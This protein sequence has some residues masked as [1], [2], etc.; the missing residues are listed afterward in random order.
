[1]QTHVAVG[2]LDLP[3]RSPKEIGAYRNPVQR[4][5]HLSSAAPFPGWMMQ[6]LRAVL[7]WSGAKAQWLFNLIYGGVPAEF[8]SAFNLDESVKR[9][10]AVTRELPILTR[11]RVAQGEVSKSYVS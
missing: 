1:M 3:Q 4:M 7:R 2:R 8:D 10:A 6:L 11:Q 5:S 9:L